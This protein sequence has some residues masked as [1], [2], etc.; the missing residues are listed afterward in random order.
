MDNILTALTEDDA[1]Y[2]E[3]IKTHLA[4]RKL[5]INCDIDDTLIENTCLMIMRWNAEDKGLPAERRKK[6]ILYINSD[7]GD[8]VLGMQLLSVMLTSKTPIITVGLSRCASMASY[9]LAAGHERYCFPNTVV[10]YHDG[11]SGYYASGNKGKDIQKFYDQLTVRLTDF[12]VKHTKMTEEY[13][14]EIKDR[15]YYMFADEAKEKGIVDYIIG[16]DCDIDFVI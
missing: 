12:M 1:L 6:I 4:E 14:E 13:L 11:Q 5:I 15:E 10:L 9:I 7:G 2:T 16:V 8:V 3:I